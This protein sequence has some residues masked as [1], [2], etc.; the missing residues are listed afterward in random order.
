MPARTSR[1]ASRPRIRSGSGNEPGPPGVMSRSAWLTG[2]RFFFVVVVGVVVVLV[3]VVEFGIGV[4]GVIFVTV[5][6]AAS[7]RWSAR[8]MSCRALEYTDTS[9]GRWSIAWW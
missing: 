7:A 1:I 4:V 2:L 8:S 5:L 3:D 9:S 6:P